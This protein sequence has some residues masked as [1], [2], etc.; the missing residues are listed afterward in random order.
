MANLADGSV[1]LVW[2]HVSFL[3]ELVDKGKSLCSWSFSYL[4]DFDADSGR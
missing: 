4:P 1:V 3:W 2:L